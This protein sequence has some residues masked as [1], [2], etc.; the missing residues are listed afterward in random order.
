MATGIVPGLRVYVPSG[1][2]ELFVEGLVKSSDNKVTVVTC[3][4]GVRH[5]LHF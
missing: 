5:T 3:A 4:A 2:K 1:D